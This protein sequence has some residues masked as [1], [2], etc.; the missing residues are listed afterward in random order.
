MENK[1]SNKEGYLASIQRRDPASRSKWSIFWLYPSVIALRWYHLSHFLWGIHFKFLAEMIMHHARKT[2][3]IEI[4]PAAKIGRNLFIDHGSGVVI[5]E[6]AEIGDGCTLYHGVT[7]GGTSDQKVKRHPTLG[8][9]VMVGAGAILL[10]PIVIGDNARIAANAVVRKD[11]PA[12][13]IVFD[14]DVHVFSKK[15]QKGAH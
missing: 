6:T 13:A 5:G 9:N 2:T 4:H 8:N 7:L 14:E 10:G 1:T 12:D 11:V 15:D 3:G